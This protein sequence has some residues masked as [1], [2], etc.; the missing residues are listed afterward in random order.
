VKAVRALRGFPDLDDWSFGVDEE[1]IEDDDPP[2]DPFVLLLDEVLLLL[3]L[4]PVVVAAFFFEDLQSF[5]FFLDS[6]FE[7][8]VLEDTRS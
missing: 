7:D 3:L 6:L 1:D 4:P 2:D 8:F 5:T